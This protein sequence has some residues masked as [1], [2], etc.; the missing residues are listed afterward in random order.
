L[1]C[2]LKPAA[3][4]HYIVGNSTFY[5]VLLPVEQIYAAM[6]DTLGFKQIEC[7]PIRKRNSKKELIEFDV[8]A[9]WPG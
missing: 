4:V 2:V 8:T 5:S 1:R 3:E 6:L 7:K 9:I